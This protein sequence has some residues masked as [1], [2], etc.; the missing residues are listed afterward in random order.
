MHLNLNHKKIFG[1]KGLFHSIFLASLI[2]ISMGIP[3]LSCDENYNPEDN[4]PKI[5][6]LSKSKDHTIVSRVKDIYTLEA[7][8]KRTYA[9]QTLVA[10]EIV[11]GSIIK[12]V[13]LGFWGVLFDATY[14]L[15]K[16]NA[17]SLLCKVAEY[18]LPEDLRTPFHNLVTYGFLGLH[19][20]DCYQNPLQQSLGYTFGLA[21]VFFVQ[22][23]LDHFALSDAYFKEVQGFAYYCFR[24]AGW[25]TGDHF[26]GFMDFFNQFSGVNLDP[27]SVI[28]LAEASETVTL[29]IEPKLDLFSPQCPTSE[30]FPTQCYIDPLCHHNPYNPTLDEL[31]F[32]TAHYEMQNIT[33][34]S[35]PET[36]GKA[37]MRSE[38]SLLAYLS[39]EHQRAETSQRQLRIILGEKHDSCHCDRVKKT[40]LTFLIQKGTHTLNLEC[41]NGSPRSFYARFEELLKTHKQVQER[42]EEMMA[43]CPKI[44]S[45]SEKLKTILPK[46]KYLDLIKGCRA[47]I[48]SCEEKKSFSEMFEDSHSKGIYDL[49]VFAT[50]KSITVH[51][52]EKEYNEDELYSI[53]H[54]D[55]VRKQISPKNKEIRKEIFNCPNFFKREQDMVR[56]IEHIQLSSLSVVGYFHLRG[57]QKF[58]KED[59]RLH[60]IY[61]SCNKDK[62]HS[63]IR[64][65]VKIEIK[66]EEIKELLS[67]YVTKSKREKCWI[68]LRK[69]LNGMFE[70]YL[71]NI[72]QVSEE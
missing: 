1:F 53:V 29:Q 39:Q 48:A 50:K 10:G 36:N 30:I 18:F 20:Y 67:P 57:I 2:L 34:M 28:V 3:S 52:I 61:I 37:G 22:H 63:D 8:L 16:H 49:I 17:P 35:C 11:S 33:L 4:I 71:D 72:Y 54:T 23:V 27:F 12:Y 66:F 59:D 40:I 56:N 41:G 6:T 43:F 26:K 7:D 68:S 21:G 44:I 15:T 65:R 5:S 19:G 13:T 62:D 69:Y 58:L 70:E 24:K 42:C 45:E 32:Y 60:T 46:N 64:M 55:T 14:N 9:Y 47:S 38:R 31:F 51:K 25:Y